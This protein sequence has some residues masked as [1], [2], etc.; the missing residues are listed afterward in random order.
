MCAADTN[1]EDV[2]PFLNSTTGWGST[3]LCRSYGEVMDWAVQWRV[4]S[5]EGVV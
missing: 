3:R 2:N 5:F 1:L 4:S